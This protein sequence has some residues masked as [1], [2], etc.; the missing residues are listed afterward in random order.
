LTFSSAL[1]LT[2][3]LCLLIATTL[4]LACKQEGWLSRKNSCRHEGIENCQYAPKCFDLKE[5]AVVWQA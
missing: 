5:A 3:S 2:T 4:L 1:T